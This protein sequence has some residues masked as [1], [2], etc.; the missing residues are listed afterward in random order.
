MMSW[1][2]MVPMPGTASSCSIWGSQGSASFSIVA[3]SWLICAV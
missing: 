3:V 2:Q 1:A